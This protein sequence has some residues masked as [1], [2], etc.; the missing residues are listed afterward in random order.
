VAGG[1]TAQDCGA[2]RSQYQVA[3]PSAEQLDRGQHQRPRI[4]RRPDHG[5]QL[6]R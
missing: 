2:L 6:H 4:V 3:R 5:S 1:A